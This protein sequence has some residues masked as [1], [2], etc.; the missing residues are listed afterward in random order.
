MKSSS[1]TERLMSS[2]YWLAIVSRPEMPDGDNLFRHVRRFCLWSR[3]LRHGFNAVVSPV[4][5]LAVAAWRC[6]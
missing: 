1:L 2:K 6:R 3:S 5:R 4:P